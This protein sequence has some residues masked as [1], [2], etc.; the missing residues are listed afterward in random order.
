MFL[1][2]LTS[3]HQGLIENKKIS[4]LIVIDKDTVPLRKEQITG[5]ISTLDI[6]SYVCDHITDNASLSFNLQEIF[7]DVE[8]LIL[9]KIS[10]SDVCRM[11]ATY[12]I[13]LAFKL[14]P[15]CR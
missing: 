7:T 14:T 10:V 6:V 13:R 4:A 11:F 1:H 9:N 3:L 15:Y 12:H 2:I 8:K 5:I